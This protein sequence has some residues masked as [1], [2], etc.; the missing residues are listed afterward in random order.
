MRLLPW[1]CLL[2]LVLPLAGMAEGLDYAQTRQLTERAVAL[3][4]DEKIDEGYQALKPH[5]PLPAVEIDN[6]A[7][8]THNQWPMVRQR[9]GEPLKMEFVHEAR[10]GE[11]LLRY[12]YIQKFERHALR[13]VF[14]FYKPE[15]QWLVNSVS[16]DDQLDRL[17]V[18]R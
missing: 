15:G 2:L 5:W 6:L 9:F 3:F 17:F 7:N 1:G 4:A 11:S 8:Q 14:T 16:F 12:V 10:A 18:V 13:W